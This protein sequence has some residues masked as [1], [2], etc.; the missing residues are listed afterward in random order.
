MDA[1]A[2]GAHD[3]VKPHSDVVTGA[4]FAQRRRERLSGEHDPTLFATAYTCPVPSPDGTMLAWISDRDGRPRAWVAPLPP[5]GSP[6]VEPAWPLPT[7]GD[8]HDRDDGVPWDVQKLSWSPDGYWLAC[9]LAPGGGERT[10]V[11]L[12][13]PDGGK[14]QDLAAHA[15]AVT[16]GSWSPRGRQVGITIFGTGSG[17]GVAC[18][19]DVRDGTSTVLTSGPAAVVCAISGDGM[20]AVVRV[21]GRVLG[22]GV[23]RTKKA[24]EQ[25]AA[26]QVD[27]DK[28]DQDGPE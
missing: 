2:A 5:D 7:D 18:L 11:R 21:G 17:D 1:H 14:V 15:A 28:D 9:Q 26:E 22:S 23:G 27:D 20:R 24:A 19:M 4:E 12:V 3:A 16:L 25:Q 10:R 6:V 13:T 8:S